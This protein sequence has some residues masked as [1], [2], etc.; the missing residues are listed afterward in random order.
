MSGAI[1]ESPGKSPV[2]PPY[3]RR[4]LPCGSG[5]VGGASAPGIGT[6]TPTSPFQLTDHFQK[7]QKTR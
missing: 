7:M 3:V 5:G 6:G 1:I 2:A 4:S